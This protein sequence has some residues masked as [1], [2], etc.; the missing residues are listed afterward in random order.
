MIRKHKSTVLSLAWCPNNKLLVTGSSDY[1][2]RIVSAFIPNLDT[3]EPEPFGSL[4]PKQD[5]FGECLVEFDQ[6]KAWVNS[7]AWSPSGFRLAFAGHGST[8][9]FVQIVAD[10]PPQV[11]SIND[12]DLPY[13][14]IQFVDDNTLVGGGWSLNP[15]V[16]KASGDAA[17]PTWAFD[18]KLD[19]ESA[20]DKKKL[21]GARAMFQD[22]DSRGHAV[23]S[24]GKSNVLTTKHQNL[25][26]N[27]Q[28]IS[29]TEISTSGY[30]GRIYFW[31]L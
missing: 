24:G 5:T 2:C 11:Q 23:G 15:T 20:G 14:S 30:G 29:S 27:V 25:I 13:N 16:Y 12:N 1:K 31:K 9:H 28:V 4:W 26:S 7:V 6:A 10:G 18:K 22:A 8:L 21:T 17:A 19:P 3:S